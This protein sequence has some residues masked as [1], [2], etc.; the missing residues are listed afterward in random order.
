VC[1]ISD[2]Q[3]CT[4]RGRERKP[5][6]KKCVK[7]TSPNQNEE[8]LG[9]ID[10]WAQNNLLDREQITNTSDM[11]FANPFE[12]LEVMFAEVPL[13]N[14]RTENITVKVPMISSE[15]ISSYAHM[16]KNWI[17]KQ[18]KVLKEWED[19]LGAML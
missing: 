12:K 16:S 17:E 3:K 10:A 9:K 14:I 6:T 19:F 4:N 13:I 8:S 15:D 11:A 1:D 5:A 2:E 18:E 7:K